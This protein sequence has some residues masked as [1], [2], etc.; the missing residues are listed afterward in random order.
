MVM[1]GKKDT[2]TKERLPIVAAYLRVSTDKQTIL[3]QKSEIINFCKHQELKITMWCTETV[4][5]AKKENER[6]F[7]ISEKSYQRETARGG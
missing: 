3:N 7:Y 5:G 4:S 6:E 2:G 1:P